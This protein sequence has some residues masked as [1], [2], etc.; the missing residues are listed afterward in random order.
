M[1]RQP[2]FVDLGNKTFKTNKTRLRLWET[3]NKTANNVKLRSAAWRRS[4]VLFVLKVLFSSKGLSSIQF[5]F[6]FLSELGMSVSSLRSSVEP[7]GQKHLHHTLGTKQLA[8]VKAAAS[9]MTAGV[10]VVTRK[11]VKGS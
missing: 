1:I 9:T 3:V 11:A 7:M 5:V 6:F 10:A 2:I 8:T 4:L